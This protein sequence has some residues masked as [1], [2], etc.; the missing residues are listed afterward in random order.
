M[1]IEIWSD[2]VCPFCYIGKK[3][4]ESALQQFEHSSQVQVVWKSFQ[5]NP[6]LVEQS[7]VDVY[8]YLAKLKGQT[9]EWS[10]KQH[11]RIAKMAANEGLIYNFDKVKI[12]NSMNAHRLMQLAKQQNKDEAMAERFFKAH[13]TEGASLSDQQTLLSLAIEAGLPADE[14]KDVLQQKHFENEVLNDHNEATDL[15]ATGVPFFV[16]DRKFAISGAQEV[17]VFLTGLNKAL[18]ASNA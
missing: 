14:V 4:F 15:G 6:A 12:C 1:L 18:Q 10:Q 17:D 2:M 9:R 13:F 5:L 16:I 8:D 3:R 11:D 7:D